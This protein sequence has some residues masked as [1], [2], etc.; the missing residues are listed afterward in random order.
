MICQFFFFFFFLIFKQ[1]CNYLILLRKSYTFF[2]SLGDMLQ[3]GLRPV[4]LSG[5]VILL[6]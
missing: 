3:L 2:L 4:R 6:L 5:H 1:L